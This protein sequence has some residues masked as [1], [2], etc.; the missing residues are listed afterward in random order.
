VVVIISI[1]NMRSV[2]F[3]AVV[4][5][6]IGVC[7]VGAQ[8]QTG[9]PN[10]WS[11]L[12]FRYIGPA[13]NRTD[14]I[15]GIP[16]DPLVY[17]AGAAS[18]GVW[19]TTDGGVHWAPL[20]DA[21]AV[22][23]IGA[24]AVAPSD[25]NIVWAGT[26]EPYI[27]SN[28]S[29]GDGMYKSTDAGKTWTH[30]GLEKTG[31]IA[32]V[33]I[34]PKNPN[35]VFACALGTAYGPQPDRGIFRTTDGGKSWEKVLFVDE[36]TGCSDL[37]MDPNNPRILFAGMWQIVI[38]TWGRTSGGPGSGLFRSDDEGS[39]WKRLE[40]H[41]LPHYPLGRI[42]VVIAKSNSDRVYALIETGDGVAW[43]GKPTQGGELWRS[44]NGGEDWQLMTYNH[45]VLGRTHYFTRAA[46]EAD[47]ENEV[48]FLTG[49]FSRTLD[50]GHTVTDMGT[51]G[52]GHDNHDM[53]IDPTNGNRMAVAND[54]GV[55]LTV[56][57]GRTWNWIRLPIGQMYH[58]TVDDNIPYFV[59][60]N[61]QDNSS[62][63]GPS[64][65]LSSGHE[66]R[67]GMI[68]RSNWISVGGDESGF[69][70]PDPVDSNIIWSSGTGDGSVGG[71]VT[72]FDMRNRQ[73][74]EVE[75]WP[76][77]TVGSPA[78]DVKYRF[79]WTFP[80]LISPHDH[81]KIYVG[82][83]YVHVTTDGGDSWQVISP[84]LTRNDKSRQGP[85]GGLTQDN[86]GVEYE[87]VVFSLAESPKL[88]GLLWAGTN[89]GLV[90]LTRDDGKTWINV[91]ANIPG[92]P[93]WGT[94]SS[95]VASRYD[96][97]TAY[98]S[99]D[100]HQQG[101]RNPFVYKTDDYGKTWTAIT[102]GITPSM[103]SYAHF[104]AEDPARQ[105]LL[106]LGTENALYI[107][108]DDGRNWQ[109][110]QMNLPHA[111]VYGIAV[112]ERFHD[113]VL[114]TYGRGFWILD[115][116]TPLEQLT[117]DVLGANAYLFRPRD[118]YRFRLTTQPNP[119]ENHINDPN[120]GQN[121]PYGADINY[122]LKSAPEGDVRVVIQDAAGHTLRTLKGTKEPGINR[123]WW[124][125]RS[126][127]THEIRLRTS[128]LYEPWFPVGPDGWR[129]IPANEYTRPI[130]VLQPPG[131]YTVKL[132]AGSQE[133]TQELTVLEDPHSTGTEA[134]IAAN[135]KLVTALAV[136]IDALADAINQAESIRAQLAD[137]NT[138]LGHA[139]DDKLI[140][141]AAASVN[142]KLMG[143]ENVMFQTMNT[144]TGEDQERW[145]A[146]LLDKL[147]Y[148]ANEVAGSDFAPTAQ[149]VAVQQ[150]LHR[151]LDS[152]LA[153]L[154][155][156]VSKELTEFNAMLRNHD[157]A[158]II[159]RT[160]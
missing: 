19:K 140:R 66:G 36:N 40:G 31:R 44:D 159:S 56:D 6:V 160:Q 145:P 45:F 87:D 133:F 3:K 39:S 158:N 54:Y 77:S 156:I 96:P 4:L 85:S 34:D 32:R 33:L 42:G 29:I 86:L 84:D 110:L 152:D 120:V 60:G 16:G 92:L 1:F 102:K 117:P 127:P 111:P 21:Q 104:I 155:E 13:G 22:Q 139:P 70:T 59:Y 107:S 55:I 62:Y 89:D 49:S 15:A 88:A 115:D 37:T 73:V 41:G 12:H 113:L 53:W 137:L 20:F 121:P 9:S 112:H 124:D 93:P 95:I 105:G 71:A 90:Q 18:G 61:E 83:Q 130:S 63:R 128:A 135:T 43:G 76:D 7:P 50:G 100:F 11:N 17:Y 138:Y 28:I 99:V 52:A 147:T 81:N 148:L 80:L 153:Q 23:S 108:F 78:S 25:P 64:N 35:V 10:P 94:V 51:R 151:Q 38:H 131:T 57:R 2:A 26:G 143:V 58:V 48:Y 119:D 123:V 116:I 141:D 146:E 47:N 118:A 142:D 8:A 79:N 126:E 134:D 91:T 149:A 82:S 129:P 97:A 27:R 132:Q 74:R 106:Y 144:G 109:P 67:P 72:R 75:V 101:D 69:A 114:A 24:L 5:L 122:F 98:I 30:M 125:L 103:C 65:S 154:H 46:V 14:A 157:V 136:D 68:T 150:L